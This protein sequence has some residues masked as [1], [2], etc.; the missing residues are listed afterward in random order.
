M[1]KVNINIAVGPAALE[2]M[3]AD[4]HHGPDGD[5]DAI[6]EALGLPGQPSLSR[7]LFLDHCEES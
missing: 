7:F 6:N 1:S 3:R 5:A 2:K 4:G